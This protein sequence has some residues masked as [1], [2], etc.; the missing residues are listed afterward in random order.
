MNASMGDT[1]NLGRCCTWIENFRRYLTPATLSP[2]VEARI[3]VERMGRHEAAPHCMSPFSRCRPTARTVYLTARDLPQY[4]GERRKFAQDLIDFDRQW[5][6]LFSGKPRT[7]DH[8][9]GVT[10]E[11]TLGYAAFSPSTPPALP[12]SSVYCTT[13][14]SLCAHV[15]AAYH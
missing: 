4:E 9:D 12:P 15:A 13:P 3:R 14:T 7:E 5:A 8:Q 1:H 11:A 2:S 10:H 6:T